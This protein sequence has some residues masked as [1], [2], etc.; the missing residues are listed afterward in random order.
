[1]RLLWRLWAFCSGIPVGGAIALAALREPAPLQLVWGA[2]AGGV[3]LALLVSLLARGHP[4]HFERGRHLAAAT[5][6]GWAAVPAAVA[7]FFAW[8]PGSWV[9]V[10]LVIAL[11]AGALFVATRAL[12]PGG[13]LV[14]WKLRA[15]ASFLIA[16]AAV[17]ALAAAGAAL[18][19]NAPEP[20]SRFSSVLDAIDA[21]VV[22]RPLPACSAEPRAVAVLLERGAHPALSPD[23][24]QLWFD[25]E[26][27]ADGG[28]RQIHRLDRATGNVICWSCGDLG[29]N[30]HPSI[31]SSGVSL[32]FQSDRHASWRHPD[33]TDLYLAAT[34]RTENPDHGRRLSFTIGPDESPV[35]GPGPMMVTWSRRLAGR[36]DVVAASIRSGHGGLLLGTPGVLANGGAEWIAPVAWSPDARS[37]LVASGNP[38]GPLALEAVDPKNFSR[39]LFATDA[40]LA[41]SFDADGGWLGFATTR[42]LHWAGVLPRALGFAVAPLAI[43]RRAREPLCRDTGVRSAASEQSVEAAA[44]AID[45]AVAS[46]G[47]PTGL[48]IEPDGSGFVLGQRHQGDD[49][50]HER[51]VAIQLACTQ[52]AVAPRAPAAP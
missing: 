44:I 5:S 31:S 15:V 2:L 3:L 48:A 10:A 14:R 29:N 46:W 40:A 21:E 22:T 12:G 35:F 9:Y 51:L 45:A 28:R 43:D 50:V 27:D 19:A 38:F 4:D 33:D 6:F 26:S 41:G 49:G 47:E 8:A 37:L 32:V 20:S 13:G 18:F 39:R 25:A 1:M 7:V 34:Q 17:L 16:S 30:V 11:L 42:P 24:A 23:G 52:T 36:Y